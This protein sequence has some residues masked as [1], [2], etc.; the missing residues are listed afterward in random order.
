MDALS[1]LRYAVELPLTPAPEFSAVSVERIEDAFDEDFVDYIFSDGSSKIYGE[2]TNEMPFD[3]S[4][5]MVIMDENNVPVD[6][7]FPAQEVK[8][9]SGEVVFEITKE[10]M[11]KMK[12]A[13]HIDLNLHLTGRDQSEALKKGQ[14]TTFNLKL[15]KEGGISI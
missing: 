4:I 13:R 6:I 2:V 12:D 15:K 8:G 3:M 9:Q 11:P 10:D 1:E 7:Q 5:E 14:K